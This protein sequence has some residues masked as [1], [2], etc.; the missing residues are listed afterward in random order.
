M[1]PLDRP[2]PIGRLLD[3]SPCSRLRL[4]RTADPGSGPPVGPRG[5]RHELKYVVRP[6]TARRLL[7][8]IGPHLTLDPHGRDRPAHA[9]TVRS[10]YF[11]SPTF[12]CFH[13][14][15]G[16]QQFREK[17]RLRTYNEP[18]SAPVHFELKQKRGVDYAKHK[19]AVNSRAIAPN[20]GGTMLDWLPGR[21]GPSADEVGRQRILFKLRRHAYRPVVLVT[22]D[23]EA[24]V[25]RWDGTARVTLDRHLRVRTARAI[26]AIHD[27]SG[28]TYPLGE[29][30]IVEVKFT[31]LVPR[32]MGA[33][34]GRLQLKTQACSKY[35]TTVAEL[36]DEDAGTRRRRHA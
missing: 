14:K 23:R 36:L 9:Y 24:Y 19:I 2:A 31:R 8:F 34:H 3:W 30:V 29:W 5:R 27:E 15:T 7:E 35:C 26:S 4:G 18:G 32:W 22:Y 25:S 16:G 20:A 13:A 10:V 12:E 6:E 1:P 17:Y 21:S 11:D 28:W 33:V